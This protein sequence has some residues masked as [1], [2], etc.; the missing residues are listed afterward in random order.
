[1]GLKKLGVVNI[2]LYNTVDGFYMLYVVLDYYEFNIIY[3]ALF[4]LLVIFSR[5]C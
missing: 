2:S 4:I 3:Y 1:M 5:G